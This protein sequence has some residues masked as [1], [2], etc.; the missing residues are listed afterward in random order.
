MDTDAHVSRESG[1][2][3]TLR[4]DVSRV[5]NVCGPRSRTVLGVRCWIG[6][7]RQRE[8]EREKGGV[9]SKTVRNG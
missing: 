9:N 6:G 5:G 3:E 4:R 2:G 8:N 7:L 1:G